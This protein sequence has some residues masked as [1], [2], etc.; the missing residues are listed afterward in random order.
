MSDMSKLI[1]RTTGKEFEEFCRR[2]LQVV[3]P[4]ASNLLQSAV[5]LQRKYLIALYFRVLSLSRGCVALVDAQVLDGVPV[6]IRAVFEAYVDLKNLAFDSNYILH[7]RAAYLWE[8]VKLQEALLGFAGQKKS[9]VKKQL[10]EYRREQRALEKGNFK[11]FTVWQRFKRAGWKDVY[12]LTYGFL[13]KASHNSITVLRDR[14]LSR[15]DANRLVRSNF[16]DLED[17]KYLFKRL[18]KVLVNASLLTHGQKASESIKILVALR[19]ELDEL[20][21][22]DCVERTG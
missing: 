13:C 9:A 12:D 6:L 15:K 8:N 14:H 2:V 21:R 16:T 11:R 19:H 5:K 3:E 7:M 20:E 1:Q 17:Q 18:A 22:R 10:Q 4:L